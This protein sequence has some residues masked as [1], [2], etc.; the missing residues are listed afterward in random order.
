MKALM[1]FRAFWSAASKA[2]CERVDPFAHRA[3][4]TSAFR[5][6]SFL[7]EMLTG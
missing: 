7:A 1:L 6:I 4:S 2:V 3:L 5:P